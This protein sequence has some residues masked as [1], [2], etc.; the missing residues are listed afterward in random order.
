MNA[1][2][3]L[4]LGN[5]WYSFVNVPQEGRYIKVEALNCG[6]DRKA[7]NRARKINPGFDYFVTEPP[8]EKRDNE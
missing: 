3:I 2:G 8:K 7:I 6:T 4:G 5:G 1:K